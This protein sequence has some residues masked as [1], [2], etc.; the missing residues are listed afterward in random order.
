METAATRLAKRLGSQ[1][2]SLCDRVSTRLLAAYPELKDTL[3]L[4]EGYNPRDRLSFMAVE[5]LSEL[6]RAVL[7]FDLPEL[8]ER[9][10]MWAHGV[11]PR[12]GVTYTHQSS[13]IAWYFEELRSLATSPDEVRL[14]R[15]LEQT[16]LGAVRSAYQLM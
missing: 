14:V 12:I 13:M 11:L 10:L 8:A 15:N 5:R 1:Y 3:R 2:K 7:V 6:V 16:F 9:E 4:D